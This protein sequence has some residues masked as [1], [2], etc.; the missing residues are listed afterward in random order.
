MKYYTSSDFFKKI[1]N[2]VLKRFITSDTEVV[3]KRPLYFALLHM[4]EAGLLIALYLK[5]F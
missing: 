2:P 5:Q 1:S 4:R 3:R